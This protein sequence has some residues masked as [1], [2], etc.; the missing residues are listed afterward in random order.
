MQNV[1]PSFFWAIPGEKPW[2]Q[3]GG[4]GSVGEKCVAWQE[5]ALQVETQRSNG[6]IAA[7]EFPMCFETFPISDIFGSANLMLRGMR[8]HQVSQMA[9][10]KSPIHHLLSCG[11][12][13][14]H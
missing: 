11:F 12:R 6:T 7:T 2:P 1:L 13:Q 8:K 4:G 10:V 9:W 5:S 3:E 14:V